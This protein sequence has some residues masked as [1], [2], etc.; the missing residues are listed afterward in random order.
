LGDALPSESFRC[1]L[2][3]VIRWQSDRQ[4]ALDHRT[5]H[6][7]EKQVPSNPD[8]PAAPFGAGLDEPGSECGIIEQ[9]GSQCPAERGFHGILGMAL[10]HQSAAQLR[11]GERAPLQ[12]PEQ[13]APG[14]LLVGG[15]IQFPYPFGIQRSAGGESAAVTRFTEDCSTA[16][17]QLDRTKPTGPGQDQRG[18]GSLILLGSTPAVITPFT[19]SESFTFCHLG[20][21]G[22]I[23][24]GTWHS[25]GLTDALI[26]VEYRPDFWMMPASAAIS[27][28]RRG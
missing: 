26:A 21:R 2:R 5:I 6:P 8:R 23:V 7:Q 20:Q 10:S 27:H 25:H 19:P 22:G 17:I 12:G 13:S 28:R 9:P 11:D 18:D 3:I 16:F 4:R 1:E 15:L 14:R 24:R